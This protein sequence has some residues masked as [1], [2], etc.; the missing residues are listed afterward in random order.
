[1]TITQYTSIASALLTF[2]INKG[3]R[4][5]PVGMLAN[6][7]V[8]V[9]NLAVTNGGGNGFRHLI[10][11]LSLRE[12]HTLRQNKDLIE[13]IKKITKMDAE[14]LREY[15]V[16]NWGLTVESCQNQ[17]W[18]VDIE[19]IRKTCPKWARAVVEGHY[20][21]STDFIKWGCERLMEE[22]RVN[23]NIRYIQ[24]LRAEAK[25]KEEETRRLQEE[26]FEAAM[27]CGYFC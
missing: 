8:I 12:L 17:D 24:E 9:A 11:H 3:L 7:G 23:L 5:L 1:M 2:F 27:G 22:V 26:Q 14:D 21:D 25:R 20:I 13:R 15:M 4:M 16:K 19:S 6:K 18:W 10:S